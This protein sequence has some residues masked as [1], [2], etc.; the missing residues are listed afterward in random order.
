MTDYIVCEFC[1]CPHRPS[2]VQCDG[3]GHTLGQPVD[4]EALERELPGLR[5]QI[6]VSSVAIVLVVIA[7]IAVFGG[8]GYVVL[9]APTGWVARSARRHRQISQVLRRSMSLRAFD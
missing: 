2:T 3:C 4:R 8:A 9:L 1:Q 6:A 7:N 5:R